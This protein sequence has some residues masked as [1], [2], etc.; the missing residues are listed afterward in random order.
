MSKLNDALLAIM[1]DDSDDDQE[2]PVTG[3]NQD[4]PSQKDPDNKTIDEVDKEIDASTE[5]LDR[6]MRRAV[7]FEVL[8]ERRNSAALISLGVKE[9]YLTS[10]SL[11]M[12]AAD[13]QVE[14]A[15]QA[16]NPEDTEAD[17]EKAAG[18]I[19]EWI[20]KA[21]STLTKTMVVLKSK[22]FH[23]S[24]DIQQ[25][26][27]KASMQV[28]EDSTGKDEKKS[29]IKAHPYVTVAACVA[30]AAAV[31][32]IIPMFTAAIPVAMT[33]EAAAASAAAST[34]TISRLIAAV[35]NIKWPFGNFSLS[36]VGKHFKLSYT[37][38]KNFVT[39]LRKAPIK[40]VKELG[41]TKS[42]VGFVTNQAKKFS[43]AFPRLSEMMASQYRSEVDM[44]KRAI[45]T[46]GFFKKPIK[47]AG[48]VFRLSTYLPFVAMG[49]SIVKCVFSLI[50]EVVFG[51]Y[52]IIKHTFNAITGRNK[53]PDQNNDEGS[54]QEIDDAFA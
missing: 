47:I 10:S 27:P 1:K 44:V 45:S 52:R 54:Q 12:E 23:S 48:A 32:A 22:I 7:F 29:F 24:Q 46:P 39:S 19:K 50:K 25:M 40:T 36:Y 20:A 2:K 11:C 37:A 21:F 8:S 9:G 13:G 18:G 30:A 41:W 42:A 15:K 43:S 26:A 16:A 5:D 33:E 6:Q 53:T 35:K 51:T 4:I 17:E 14:P 28:T 49:W 34:G 31:M 38:T 3:N